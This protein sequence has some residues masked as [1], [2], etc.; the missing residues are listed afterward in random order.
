MAKQKDDV[1][2]GNDV[3]TSSRNRGQ[4]DGNQVH[5]LVELRTSMPLIPSTPLPG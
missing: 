3:D 4:G 1:T 5:E 2:K